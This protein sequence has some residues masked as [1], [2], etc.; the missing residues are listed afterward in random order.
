[1]HWDGTYCEWDTTASG[2]QPYFISA[3]YRGVLAITGLW[4][5]WKDPVT[6]EA[7]LSCTLIATAGSEFAR[8]THGRMLVPRVI[9]NEGKAAS[10]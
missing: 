9:Q 3:A 6:G 7:L 4:N 8:R 1:V 10:V 5:R 2:N